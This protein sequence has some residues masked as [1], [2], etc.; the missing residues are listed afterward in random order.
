MTRPRSLMRPTSCRCGGESEQQTH[1]RRAPAEHPGLAWVLVHVRCP[2]EGRPRPI[3]LEPSGV[4]TCLPVNRR[5][6]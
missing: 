3:R 5:F 1:R 4:R 6:D 2:R